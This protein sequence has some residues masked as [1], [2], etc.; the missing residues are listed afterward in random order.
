MKFDTHSTITAIATGV[1]GA[2]RGALRVSGPE[3]L[4]VVARAFPETATWIAGC[5][6]ARSFEQVLNCTIMGPVETRCFV[7]PNGRSY[8]GQPSVEIHTLGAPVILDALQ[9]QLLDNGAV[10]AQPGEFTLR[11][12]LAGRLDLT[13]C[14]AV[15][16]VIHATSDKS[17]KVALQQL[18]G[19]LAAPLSEL[20]TN[21]INLLADIEAGLDFVDEDI[22]FITDDQISERLHD[23]IERIG[24]LIEQMD[25]RAAQSVQ[26]QVAIVGPPNS[27]KSSLLNALGG[28]DVSIVSDTPGT[29]RDYVKLLIEFDGIAIDFLDTAG[30][31]EVEGDSPR[32]VAQQ[33][34]REQIENADLLIECKSLVTA[35][36]IASIPESTD[37]TLSV[38]VGAV[39]RW[40]VQTKSDLIGSDRVSDGN[41]IDGHDL[42]PASGIWEQVFEVSAKTGLG[43][44]ELRKAIDTWAHGE[45]ALQSQVVP[46]TAKRC[47]SSLV[48]AHDALTQALHTNANSAGQEIVA[49]E[50]RLALEEIGMVVGEIYTEDILDA[51]FSRFCIGK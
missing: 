28:R 15:L 31:E 25:S 45:A 51:L 30:I 34:T 37:S 12:F 47:Y 23:A 48:A 10:L 7:W 3:A 33:F 9:S 16:G 5:S 41:M 19:G 6:S 40:L 1:D 27:G 50:M 11:A 18:A 22:S 39:S 36:N 49:G 38:K 43:L 44:P 24:Q 13:Q 4:H 32:A 35:D 26:L 2:L 17:L 42:A 21:L 20:R 8:T 29:T 14:E 46:A